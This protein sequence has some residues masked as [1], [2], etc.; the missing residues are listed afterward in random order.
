LIADLIHRCIQR[1]EKAAVVFAIAISTALLPTLSHHA[2]KNENAKIIEKLSLSIRGAMFL[3]VPSTVGL[4][5][6]RVPI[7]EVLFERGAFDHAATLNTAFA[8][9]FYALGLMAYSGVKLFVSAFYAIGDT[10]T[11]VKLAVAAMLINIVLNLVLMGPLRHGG[12]ALATALASWINLLGLGFFLRKRF[13]NIDGNTIFKSFLITTLISLAMAAGIRLAWGSIFA[14]GFTAGGLALIIMLAVV[15]YLACS[16]IF[17]QPEARRLTL[18][19]KK[20]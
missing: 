4:I 19:L 17:G 8:L 7:I 10:K 9:A 14:G 18:W 3:I 15:L 16:L 6:L 2:G 1:Q 13:G 12:L 11:P 5:I 20:K